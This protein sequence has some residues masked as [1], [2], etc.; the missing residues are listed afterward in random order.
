M[1]TRITASGSLRVTVQP[2]P[3]RIICNDRAQSSHCFWSFSSSREHLVVEPI[4]FCYLDPFL[5]GMYIPVNFVGVAIKRRVHQCQRLH[6]IR[7]GERKVG[8][9]TAAHGQPDHMSLLY[10]KV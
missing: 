9:Y 10:I 8:G 6:L 4:F 7:T 3:T 2:V 5:L 1:V